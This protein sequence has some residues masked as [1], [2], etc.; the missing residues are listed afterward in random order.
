MYSN[1]DKQRFIVHLKGINFLQIS[2]ENT[3]VGVT[4]VENTD[5]SREI[6]EIFKYITFNKTPLM[7]ASVLITFDFLLGF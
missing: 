4:C 1:W 2:Q 7:P 6:C 3:R 5:G